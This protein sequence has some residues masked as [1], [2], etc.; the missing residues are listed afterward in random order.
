[1]FIQGPVAQSSSMMRPGRSFMSAATGSSTM[2]SKDEIIYVALLDEGIDVWRPVVARR[3][4]GDTYLIADQDY[5]RDAET[6]EFEPGTT[7]RCR[8]KQ[9]DGRQILVARDMARTAPIA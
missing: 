5:D 1:M 2:S 9:R 7:V 4:S 6:W 8:K 3:I